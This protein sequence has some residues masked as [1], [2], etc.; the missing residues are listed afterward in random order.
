MYIITPMVNLKK[1]GFRHYEDS[2]V[3]VKKSNIAQ[4]DKGLFTAKK[5]TKKEVITYYSGV[6]VDKSDARKIRSIYHKHIGESVGLVCVGDDKEPG[7]YANGKHPITKLPKVNARFD[8]KKIA[9]V[10]GVSVPGGI[11]FVAGM[12]IKIPIVASFDLDSDVEVIVNY[13]SLA[14]WSNADAFVEDPPETST[15]IANE[16]R[17]ERFN[18]RAMYIAPSTYF[19]FNSVTGLYDYDLGEGVFSTRT[20]LADVKILTLSGEMINN[21]TMEERHRLGKG[22]YFV[23]LNSHEILDCYDSRKKLNC[24]GSCV[25]SA[26]ENFPVVH[27]VTGQPGMINC[28]L[29]K[30]FDRNKETWAFSYKTTRTIPPNTEFLADYEP[31]IPNRDD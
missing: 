1:I 30:Y 25:N 29:S 2:R 31:Y 19:G 24:K 4:A 10:K 3:Y 28:K 18:K 21:E 14:F 12:D 5:F 26:H 9:I 6:L 11:K 8:M 23:K 7:R 20:I 15:S 27:K 22:G 16:K 17:D 13:N